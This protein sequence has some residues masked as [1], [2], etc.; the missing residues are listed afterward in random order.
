MPVKTRYTA[1]AQELNIGE[2]LVVE[3][4]SKGAPSELRGGQQ[5]QSK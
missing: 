3:Y 4:V 1:F 5:V 2:G